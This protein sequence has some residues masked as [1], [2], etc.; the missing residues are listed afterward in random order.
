MI[1]LNLKACSMSLFLCAF[2][3]QSM[4]WNDAKNFRFRFIDR[5]P[6]YLRWLTQPSSFCFILFP[7]SIVV[8]SVALFNGLIKS[9][10]TLLFTTRLLIESAKK[11]R[12]FGVPSASVWSSVMTWMAKKEV[13]LRKEQQIS[14]ARNIDP[15]KFAQQPF[16]IHIW[17]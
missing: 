11:I 1:T 4:T 3:L 17:S 6:K 15:R 12:F 9:L 16:H 5:V 10:S 8:Y 7:Y 14:H 13:R 2:M